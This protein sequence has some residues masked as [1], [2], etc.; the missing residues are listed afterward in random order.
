MAAGLIQLVAY[1]VQ[2]LYLTGDP[3]ITFFKILYRR[4]TNFS[5]ESVIQNFSAS[6]NFGETVTCTISRAGDLVGKIFL[7]VEIPALPKFVNQNTGE[8]DIIKKIAW[9]NNL[10]YALVQEITIEIGGKQI[11]KQYGEW[12]YIWSQVSNRQ[13]HALDK[14]IGNVPMIYEF[15]NGKPGYQLYI[16]LEFWFCRNTGLSLPLIALASSDI[17]ITVTF[18]RLDECYRIGP[19]NSIEILE[20]IV[21]FE[22]GDYIEQTVNKQTIYGYVISY[23]YLQKKLYYIKIQNPNASKKTFESYQEPVKNINDQNKEVSKELTNLFKESV[24]HAHNKIPAV[25][26]NFIQQKI[27]PKNIINNINYHDN[28]SYRIYNSITHKYC[29]PKPNTKE[30][31]EQT[32]LVNKPRFVNSFLYVNYVYLDNDERNKFSRTNHEYL[33]EQ[34]QFN[35]E[36]GVKSPNVK[37]NLSLNHPCKAHYWV[38]QLDSLVGPGTINDLFNYTTSHIHH[39]KINNQSDGEQKLQQSENFYGKNIVEKAKLIINGKARFS[40][41]GPEFFNLVEPYQHH[42]RGPAPGIN[43]YSVSIY[44]EDHQPSSTINMSKIDYI[45]M[46]MRLDN[47]I[48]MQN[49]V[50]I[51]SYTINYNILRICFNLGG[52]A[53]V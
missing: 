42:H 48:N 45:S 37:Q 23:D 12:M 7:Y 36:I 6:A 16:P 39:D 50:K 32:S 35:Q 11:D 3:Q 29:T 28:I 17:K 13:N 26:N 51:R 46:Q 18:R 43:V 19:T 31:I 25:L 53:F 44:Q 52:L 9:V 49:T 30:L 41:R 22:P 5:I 15:S 10:G 47:S 38:G 34:I 40:E 4:H 20:D 33:I 2:D 1:G 14:M 21:P 8:E 24:E 27:L